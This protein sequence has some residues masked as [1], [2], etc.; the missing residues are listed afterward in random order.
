M[1]I[2][3]SYNQTLLIPTIASFLVIFFGAL[4]IQSIGQ[5]TI[6]V[7]IFPERIKDVGV[8]FCGAF[9]WIFS[10]FYNAIVP[11]SQYTGL[12]GVELIAG[13]IC[14][15]GAIIIHLMLPETKGKSR[16]EITKSF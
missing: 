1:I 2:G 13:I 5:Y 11:A 12:I 15:I 8:I 14:L 4:G 9:F 10:Y 6:C 3:F 7:E 16:Q